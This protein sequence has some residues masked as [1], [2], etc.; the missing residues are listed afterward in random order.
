[1]AP[2]IRRWHGV[3]QLCKILMPTST[4]GPH[5]PSPA[6]IYNWKM[7][8]HTGEHDPTGRDLPTSPEGEV[9]CADTA[10]K[11]TGQPVA[12]PFIGVLIVPRRPTWEGDTHSV[13]WPDSFLTKPSSTSVSTNGLFISLF[14]HLPIWHEVHRPC[15]LTGYWPHLMWKD[16][17]FDRPPIFKIC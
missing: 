9:E 15:L 7:K 10:G 17:L 5:C 6:N 8:N 12:G 4:V 2:T 1:M 13:G 11:C 16:R 14:A 3:R